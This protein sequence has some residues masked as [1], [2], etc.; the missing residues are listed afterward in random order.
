MKMEFN[1]VIRLRRS[2]RGYDPEKKVTRE[3]I[4]E[5]I[6]AAQLAPTWKNSQTG[7][8]YVLNG[9]LLDKFGEECLPSF[10]YK[11]SSGAALVVT[12]F[13][14]G[15]SGFTNGAADNELGNLW[16]AYDLGLQ[17]SYMVLKAADLGL[18]SL[19]MG[20]RDADRIRDLLQVPAEEEI[21]SVIAVG[22][23]AGEPLFRERKPLDE[24]LTFVD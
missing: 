13:V 11:N 9:D 14:K 22:Y 1:E 12:A 6:R 15:V 20:L 19:I 18:D 5:I 2:V 16:G 21:V 7:R 3:Q 24:I 4:E 8:Y 17:N 23:R 10:N